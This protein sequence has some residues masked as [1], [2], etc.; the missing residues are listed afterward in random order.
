MEVAIAEQLQ[1]RSSCNWLE[2]QN[3]NMANRKCYAALQRGVKHWNQW[4]EKQFKVQLDLKGVNL[5]N[6]KFI[7]VNFTDVNLSGANLVK[8]NLA[9]AN[10]AGANLSY[11]NL[12]AANLT[13]SSLT[14]ANLTGAILTKANSRSSELI[15]SIVNLGNFVDA[16]LRVADFSAAKL[17]GANF[18]QANLKEAKFVGTN[19]TRANFSL[20]NLENAD[21]SYANL[22]L[23]NLAKAN[24]HFSKLHQADLS[25]ANLS[26]ANLTKANLTKANLTKADLLESNLIQANLTQAN[27]DQADIGKA[28]LSKANL[29][30]ANLRATRACFTIF[31]YSI[32]TAACIEKLVINRQTCFNHVVCDYLYLRYERA[33]RRPRNIETQMSSGEFTAIIEQ[34]L[35][36]V[37]LVFEEPLDWSA[38]IST[39][40]KLQLQYPTTAVQI[41]AVEIISSDH[42]LVVFQ[43]S[44]ELD[45]V[46]VKK[47]LW[48]KYR[49]TLLSPKKPMGSN[50]NI[51]LTA[52]IT[53]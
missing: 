46:A 8:V 25:E 10:L 1:I 3:I 52:N 12:S 53:M 43:L 16:D 29:H 20:A 48:Q 36:T 39:F 37:E 49:L 17:I 7:G 15:G 28:N 41:K 11:A 22:S 23:A 21:F 45:L 2:Q 27:L 40:Q 50:D 5:S 47:F 34:L 4:R 33:L 31:N 38:L 19:L 24:L 30:K 18:T 14:G 32:L 42:F 26:C 35:E 9:G 13:G 44:T 6:K 51:N